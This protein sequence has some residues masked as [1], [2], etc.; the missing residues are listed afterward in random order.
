MGPGVSV[1][2]RDSSLVRLQGMRRWWLAAAAVAACCMV[3]SCAGAQANREPPTDCARV[4]CLALTFDD[5]PGD[6]TG[7]LLDVLAAR[8]VRA[9]FFV[10]GRRAREHPA[11]LQRIA[12]EGHEIGNHTWSHRR[13]TQLRRSEV[14]AE[15]RRTAE[16]IRDVTGSTPRLVR[17]PFGSVDEGVTAAINAP[18]ILW[19]VDPRDWSA[20]DSGV[21]GRRVAAEARP[22]SIVVLHDVYRTTVDAVPLIIDVLKG[23]GYRFVTVSELFSGELHPGR[24]YTERPQSPPPVG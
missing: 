21:V 8:D 23:A 17:P 19:S 15:L 22:G 16:A 24:T 14:E 6:H 10:L 1:P 9:T 13:L 11:A 4:R 3:A 2:G 5:G 12:A 18:I 7:R 20:R